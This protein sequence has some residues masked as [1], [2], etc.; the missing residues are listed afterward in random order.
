MT[1]VDNNNTIIGNTDEICCRPKNCNDWINE[2]YSCEG[3]G[4][5]LGTL[6]D[7]ADSIVAEAGPGGIDRNLNL[8]FQWM[9]VRSFSKFFKFV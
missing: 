3:N 2:G 9:E 7:N 5:D 1:R 8:M 4:V 6:I